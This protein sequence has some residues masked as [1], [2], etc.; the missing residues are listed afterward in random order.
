MF[1][2]LSAERNT[3]STMILTAELPTIGEDNMIH[4]RCSIETLPA[5]ATV[6]VPEPFPERSV[7]MS[8]V[9]TAHR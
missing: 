5:L 3:K 8:G 6:S 4:D 7:E 9:E 2:K 1:N